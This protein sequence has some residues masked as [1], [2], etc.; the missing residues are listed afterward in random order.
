MEASK[1]TD[2][3]LFFGKSY[4]TEIHFLK[5]MGV[6]HFSCSKRFKLTPTPSQA[7]KKAFFAN[8][9]KKKLEIKYA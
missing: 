8:R 9:I 1:K 3:V 7:E 2:K 4:D 5:A 6:K